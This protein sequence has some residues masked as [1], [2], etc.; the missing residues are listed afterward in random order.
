M[1]VEI[2]DKFVKVGNQSRK[3]TKTEIKK[4][5]ACFFHLIARLDLFK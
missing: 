5:S 3:S 4:F 1:Q 2:G